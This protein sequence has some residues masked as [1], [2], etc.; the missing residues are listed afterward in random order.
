MRFEDLDVWKRAARL[1]TN[2]YQELQNCRDY[3]FKDQVTRSSLSIAS[4]VA[5]GFERGSNRDRVKFLTYAKGSSGELRTQV[6][7]GIEAGF[8]G[9]EVGR[10]WVSETEEISRMLQS[11]IKSWSG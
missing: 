7:I 10:G 11:L 6:Y 2:I 5:E 9:R 8:I 1:S 3:G 4:N